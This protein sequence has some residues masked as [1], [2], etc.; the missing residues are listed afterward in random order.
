MYYFAFERSVLELCTHIEGLT[1]STLTIKS[2]VHYT[3]LHVRT[4][5]STQDLDATHV[6]DEIL[7]HTIEQ[8]K[9]ACEPHN[10]YAILILAHYALLEYSDYDLLGFMQIPS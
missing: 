6:E 3:C 1:F 2:E 8:R 4:G 7:E 9:Q 5:N 10:Y